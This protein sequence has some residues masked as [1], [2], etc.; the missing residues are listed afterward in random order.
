MSDSRP[1]AERPDG[2]VWRQALVP[3]E[4]GGWSFLAEPILLGLLVAFS[5]AGLLISLAAV[6]AFLARR[7]FRLLLSDRRRGKRYPRTLAAERGLAACAIVGS[8]ALAGGLLWARGSVLPAVGLAAPL[9]AAALAFDLG[10]RSRE[11]PAEL[12][13]ALAIAA[14]VSAIALSSGWRLAP[15]LGLWM[16]LAAR[17]VPTVLYVRARL[18]MGR[19][20]PAGVASALA[21]HAVALAFA[22]AL[23]GLRLVPWLAVAAV[24]LLGLRAA[25]NLSALRPS[26]ST[27]QLGLTEV[28]FGVTTVALVA[29]GVALRL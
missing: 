6:A 29:V 25:Y 1:I 13:A 22:A 5:T 23:A 20:Q 17:D 15:A 11:L 7:P 27:P 21:A 3:H 12:T 18:R 26:L 10:Q 2:R 14:T 4:H 8:L 19:G 24:A 16:V 9:A 28:V